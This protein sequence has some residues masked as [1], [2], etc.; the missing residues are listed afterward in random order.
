MSLIFHNQLCDT[1]LFFILYMNKNAYNVNNKKMRLKNHSVKQVLSRNCGQ[2]GAASLVLLF[3]W[4][5]DRRSINAKCKQGL[6]HLQ[7]ELR[8]VLPEER[9][10]TP[11]QSRT[12]HVK[13]F[14]SPNS[15]SANA[16]NTTRLMGDVAAARSTWRPLSTS[17]SSSRGG[18][19]SESLI[20]GW[21]KT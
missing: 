7:S 13:P 20:S 14:L 10:T 8:V 11:Q 15:K 2:R 19:V 6:S 17:R 18:H 3:F 12:A 16:A 4:N 1:L 5:R 9:P 21:A